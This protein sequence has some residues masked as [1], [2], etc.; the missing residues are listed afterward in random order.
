MTDQGHGRRPEAALMTIG[1]FARL[2]RL[3]AKALRRYDELGLLE[4]V[5]GAFRLDQ[6]GLAG[7]GTHICCVVVNHQ[8]SALPQSSALQLHAPDP[9]P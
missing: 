1:A 5:L 2:S 3:S 4:P 8:R 6:A 9:A 7:P